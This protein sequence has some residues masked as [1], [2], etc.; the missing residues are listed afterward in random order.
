MTPSLHPTAHQ[1]KTQIVDELTWTP[2]VTADHIGVVVT[3]G[4]VTLSGEVT[5]YLEKTTAV[6]ATLRLRG[7]T[8]VADELVV[9][10]PHGLRPDTDLA[11]DATTAITRS[12][13]AG[14]V[15][16]EVENHWITLTGTTDWHFQRQN[17][18]RAVEAIAGV[19][20][21]RDL[22]TLTPSQ[23]FSADEATARITAAL[24]RNATTDAGNVHVSTDGSTIELSGHVSSWAEYRQADD[25]AY[26]TPGVTHVR[27]LLHITP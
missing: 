6:R 26:S 13:G 25:V 21:V 22:I 17:A 8:A 4:A 16:A 9:K 15:K 18:V 11:R 19:N 20:G 3:D 5:S 10:H 12:P 14:N 27:N 2:D 7:V 1:L 24:Q 23:P